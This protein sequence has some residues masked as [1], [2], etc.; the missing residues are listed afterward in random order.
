MKVDEY[1]PQFCL[2]KYVINGW[3]SKDAAMNPTL[4]ES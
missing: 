4:Y 3:F 1:E 2:G